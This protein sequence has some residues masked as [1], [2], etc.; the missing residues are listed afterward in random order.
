MPEHIEDFTPAEQEFQKVLAALTPQ[1]T[2]LS[3]D[4]LIFE[5]GRASVPRGGAGWKI[6]TVFMALIAATAI[7]L[8]PDNFVNVPRG[9]AQLK[10]E[11]APAVTSQ[12][13]AEGNRFAFELIA[14]EPVLAVQVP[15]GSYLQLRSRILATG[16]LPRPPAQAGRALP[17][18]NT[19]PQEQSLWQL[20]RQLGGRS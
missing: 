20:R 11:S 8:R 9:T 1:S 13:P 12:P 3:R 5:A 15:D 17:S 19:S 10:T 7:L 14:A 2:T 16:E 18:D 4:A 6:A